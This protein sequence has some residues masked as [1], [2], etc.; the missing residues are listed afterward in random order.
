MADFFGDFTQALVI[1]EGN[2]PDRSTSTSNN[3]ISQRSNECIFANIENVLQVQY[4]EDVL[5]YTFQ[6]ELI[7]NFKPG[8]I[9]E[10]EN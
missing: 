3:I 5:G 8:Y 6:K 10:N 4:L 9:F 7:C 1:L 2:I